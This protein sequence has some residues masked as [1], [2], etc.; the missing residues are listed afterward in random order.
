MRARPDD[1]GARRPSARGRGSRAA[2]A[3]AAVLAAAALLLSPAA[4]T[5]QGD[6]GGP[7]EPLLV[8]APRP[9]SLGATGGALLWGEAATRSPEDG[10]LWGL[11]VQR[12]LVR[13]AWARVGAGFGTSTVTG[14]GR[15]VDVDSY[16][17]EVSVGPRIALP[18]LR[19]AGVV[20]F[21]G[22]TLGTLVHDPTRDGLTS[23]S[24]N[25]F[26]WGAGVAWS[27]HPR[28]GVRAEWRR[29]EVELED[30]FAEL[31]RTGATRD[32]HRIQ[33]TLY[34]TF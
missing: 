18:A 27:F 28:L 31:D 12:R 25:A 14:D 16:L 2:A 33:A 34:W 22:V 32:A 26:A 9:F 29:Y 20:P 8:E 7:A 15:S 10:G 17:F 24:Q 23:R 11:E 19:R 30:L 4:G 3:V 5:A 21:A 1:A 13:W 6:A